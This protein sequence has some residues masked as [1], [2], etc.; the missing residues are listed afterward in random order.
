MWCPFIKV[1][2]G[3][4][5][6]L[7]RGLSLVQHV[8]SNSFTKSPRTF[9]HT[10][11]AYLAM[12]LTVNRQGFCGIPSI[13]II[14]FWQFTTNF[15]WQSHFVGMCELPTEEQTFSSHFVILFIRW[16]FGERRSR[17]SVL[18]LPYANYLPE[19]FFSVHWFSCVHNASVNLSALCCLWENLKLMPLINYIFY[20]ISIGGADRPLE[21]HIPAKFFITILYIPNFNALH[22]EKV[23]I[24]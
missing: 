23:I 10:G 5:G 21:V 4:V 6:H 8:A 7:D 19:V 13:L 1:S 24:K 17:I 20:F 2:S 12:A 22:Q 18:P 14:E 9:R 3:T 16:L 15:R 11:A